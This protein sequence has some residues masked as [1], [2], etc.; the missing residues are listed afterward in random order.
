MKKSTYKYLLTIYLILMIFIS[1]I[2]QGIN[3]IGGLSSLSWE[4]W[5]MI[6]RANTWL[7]ELGVVMHSISIKQCIISFVQFMPLG[8]LLPRV[9]SK[10][11]SN[12]NF[13]ISSFIIII[14]FKLVKLLTLTGYFDITSIIIGFIGSYIIY[15]I[16]K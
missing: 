10:L 5:T 6:M 15:C 16:S 7:K 4:E 13:I 1:Y 12:K 3:N 8:Y 11:N 2:N 9:F 14:I